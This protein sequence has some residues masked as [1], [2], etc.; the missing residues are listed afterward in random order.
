[1][2]T[3]S[4]P[5]VTLTQGRGVL[6]VYKLPSV[7]LPVEWYL[8]CTRHCALSSSSQVPPIK[9]NGSDLLDLRTKKQFLPRQEKG[10]CHLA[11]RAGLCLHKVTGD[12]NISLK[13]VNN[14]P[15]LFLE[16][17]IESVTKNTGLCMILPFV[18]LLLQITQELSSMCLFTHCL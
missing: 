7:C 13:L 12:N 14:D 6:S 15:A 18:N 9:P 5:A 10:R 8:L 11:G 4:E 1:M 3:T 16:D 2:T 17:S